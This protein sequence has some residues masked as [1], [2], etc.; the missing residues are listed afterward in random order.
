VRRKEGTRRRDDEKGRIPGTASSELSDLFQLND[1]LLCST[2]SLVYAAR[3][4]LE[5]LQL[6]D[7]QQIAWIEGAVSS[8]EARLGVEEDRGADRNWNKEF[9]DIL[10]R[11]EAVVMWESRLN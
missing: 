10:G 7:D 9:Q 8:V 5:Q 11:W 2:L 4:L 6:E 1:V 3:G